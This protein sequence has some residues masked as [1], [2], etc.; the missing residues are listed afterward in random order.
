MLLTAYL[1]IG[2]LVAAACIIIENRQAEPATVFLWRKGQRVETVFFTTML[3]LG[4]PPLMVIV[5]NDK[6]KAR[7]ARRRNQSFLRI[8]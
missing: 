1:A 3:V 7:I 2:A 4:W 5:V 8:D 6:I